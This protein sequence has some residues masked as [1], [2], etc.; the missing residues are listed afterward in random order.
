VYARA[1][2]DVGAATGADAREVRAFLAAQLPL[3][4]RD[5]LRTMTALAT[6][7][8]PYLVERR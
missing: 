7:S 6:E 3:A 4:L 5:R 8:E 2:E 1:L